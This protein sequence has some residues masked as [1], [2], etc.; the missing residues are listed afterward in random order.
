AASRITKMK[1]PHNTPK[2]VITVLNQLL[3]KASIISDQLSL[4]NS[5]LISQ[6]FYGF[7]IRGVV[8]RKKSRNGARNNKDHYRAN[9]HG[10][11]YRRI[12]DV[13]GLNERAH[14]L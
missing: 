4:L 6:G 11:I 10:K 7:N 1:M 13:I 8:G 12:S 14:E 2:A 3:L 9:G 5:L